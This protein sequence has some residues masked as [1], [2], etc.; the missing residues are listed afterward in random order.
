M[1]VC[2]LGSDSMLWEHNLFFNSWSSRSR[3]GDQPLLPCFHT[4]HFADEFL[5]VDK[6]FLFM[7]WKR[8]VDCS[9]SKT[10]WFVSFRKKPFYWNFCT[11]GLNPL[12]TSI[13][14]W[15]WFPNAFWDPISILIDSFKFIFSRIKDRKTKVNILSLLWIDEA[16]TIKTLSKPIYECRCNGRLQ[17][18]R[19]T[20]LSHTGSVVAL[21]HLKMKTRLTNEK[22][23]SVK[24][25]CEI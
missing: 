3:S 14:F 5:S 8:N 2:A 1:K 25:E 20:R 4:P 24:G 12:T 11:I 7:S 17:T 9:M 21:E 22:F 10:R 23:A 13:I 18:K 6:R 16:K 19:F 15:V